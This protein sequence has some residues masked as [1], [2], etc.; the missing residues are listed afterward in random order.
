MTSGSWWIE[1]SAPCSPSWAIQKCGLHSVPGSPV[2]VSPTCPQW[3]PAHECL[4]SSPLLSWCFQDLL[5]NELCTCIQIL[6]SELASG[7]TKEPQIDMSSL[8]KYESTNFWH[9]LKSRASQLLVLKMSKILHF[10]LGDPITL[11]CGRH[12]TWT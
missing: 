1:T 3:L 10:Y 12:F 11:L 6:F 4:F 8:T 2:G 5:S 9:L 7:R